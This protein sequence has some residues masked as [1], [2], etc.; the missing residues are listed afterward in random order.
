MPAAL[1]SIGTELTRGELVNTNA[2]WIADRLTAFGLEVEVIEAIPDDRAAIVDTLRRLSTRHRVVIVTGGLGPT[3]DDL[4]SACAA[5][6]AGVPLER[7]EPSLEAIRRR[8]ASFGREMG[9]SNAKQADFPRGCEILP[10]P[11]GT[12]PGFKLQLGGALLFFTPGVP[13][14]MR[15]MFEEQIVPHIAPLATND[16]AQVHLKTFGAGESKIGEMLEGLEAEF[17]GVTL[18]YRAHFPEIEVKVFAR[19]KHRSDAQTLADAAARAV[20][21]RL[22]D[23]VYGEGREETFAACVSRVLRKGKLSLSIAESCTG[24]IVG[25]MLTALPGSSDI[26][27]FDGVVYSNTAKVQVL[28]VDEEILRAHGAVSAECARAMV[29]GV[30]RLTGSDVAVAITGIAGPTGGTDLK[31]VGLVYFAV[32]GPHDTI[33]KE[34][35]LSGDRN[36]VQTFAAWY[37]LKL[38]LDMARDL[39]ETSAPPPV[40]I[41]P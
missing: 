25:S 13:V 28:G 15:R 19:A 38:L 10:N 3:T 23:L 16:A 18:G 7:H 35:Q 27:L 37:A 39:V 26:L 41:A 11:I 33:V 40:S 17:P 36:R 31:P 32:S 34:R 14:E 21:S 29:E 8:F 24:G 22:G 4:T 30:K 20:R 12:A 5:E 2:S 6:A 1:L 9:P